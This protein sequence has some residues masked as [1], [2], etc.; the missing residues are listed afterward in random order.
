MPP[1][2][3]AGR[4]CKYSTTIAVIRMV[5]RATLDGLAKLGA[6]TWAVDGLRSVPRFI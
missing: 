6:P 2:P 3:E 4:H 1:L 5:V